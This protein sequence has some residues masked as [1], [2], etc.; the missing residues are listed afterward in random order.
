MAPDIDQMLERV[1]RTRTRR[2]REQIE[3]GLEDA[4]SELWMHHR[5]HPKEFFLNSKYIGSITSRRN[6]YHCYNFQNYFLYSTNFKEITRINLILK[7]DI[8]EINRLIQRFFPFEPFKVAELISKLPLSMIYSDRFALRLKESSNQ[9][10]SEDDENEAERN[11]LYW[12]SLGCCYILTALRRLE[13][14]KEG[15][16]ILFQ[17]IK[18]SNKN[19][20]FDSNI[21]QQLRYIC[22][23]DDHTALFEND[24]LYFT[25]RLKDFRGSVIPYIKEEL[26]YLSALVETYPRGTRL[27]RDEL[28]NKMD[29]SQRFQKIY[30]LIEFRNIRTKRPDRTFFD[31]RIRNSLEVIASQKGLVKM[32][33]DGHTKVFIKI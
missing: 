27:I 19:V 29:Y 24:M 17:N 28:I 26:D 3:K 9:E 30:S 33:K 6:D 31:N 13:L 21:Y 8:E 23:I 11:L 14:S 2:E 7:E 32:V 16:N 4:Y 10:I 5:I 12:D 18:N 1:A 22:D 20:T 15:R 25:I